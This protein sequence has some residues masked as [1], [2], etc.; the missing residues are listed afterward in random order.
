ME[1][2][3]T[4]VRQSIDNKYMYTVTVGLSRIIWNTHWYSA[5]HSLLDVGAWISDV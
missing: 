2:D 5:V 3:V 4:H 1:C